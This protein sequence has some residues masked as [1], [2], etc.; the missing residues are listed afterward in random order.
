MPAARSAAGTHGGAVS[1]EGGQ[2]PLLA[3]AAGNARLCSRR[4]LPSHL[5]SSS[6]RGGEERAQPAGRPAVGG[7]R[8][9][10]RPRGG[11]CPEAH[12]TDGG[13]RR[14]QRGRSPGQKAE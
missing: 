2:H 11:P 14:R 10:L 1:G 5:S 7:G 3:F 12:G 9:V 8:E 4:A 13:G 6:L